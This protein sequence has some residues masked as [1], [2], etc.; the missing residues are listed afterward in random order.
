MVRVKG[1]SRSRAEFRLSPFASIHPAQY[2]AMSTS[3]E[4]TPSDADELERFRRDWKN[5]VLHRR[6]KPEA[7]QD[8]LAP[9][10]ASLSLNA[11]DPSPASSPTRT[12]NDPTRN[13]PPLPPPHL[14]TPASAIAVYRDAVEHEQSGRLDGALRLYRRAFQLDDQVDRLYDKSER[15]RLKSPEQPTTTLPTSPTQATSSTSTSH[16]PFQVNRHLGASYDHTT[17]PSESFTANLRARLQDEDPQFEPEEEGRPV[18]LEKLPFEALVLV[19]R[20]LGQAGD[21]GSILRFSGVCKKAF[22]ISTEISIWKWVRS[23]F[24]GFRTLR[25]I[26]CSSSLA[27]RSSLESFAN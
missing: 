6:T 22:I 16:F 9:S 12:L 21:V 7:D 5:E 18:I 8:P 27:S 2:I 20:A 25:S 15:Q 1:S 24:L 10:L 23:S 14:R 3:P 13:L 17:P 4:G 26:Y 19:L 11:V